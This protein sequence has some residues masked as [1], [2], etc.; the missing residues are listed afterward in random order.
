VNRISNTEPT[1]GQTTTP[2]ME[3]LPTLVLAAVDGLLKEEAALAMQAKAPSNSSPE[4]SLL[5]SEM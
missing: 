2:E 5:A 3:E 1:A 4:V